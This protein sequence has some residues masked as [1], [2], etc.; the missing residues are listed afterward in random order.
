MAHASNNNNK[1]RFRLLACIS[2]LPASLPPQLA[3]RRRLRMPGNAL[4]SCCVAVRCVCG[5]VW[6]TGARPLPEGAGHTL[7]RASDREWAVSQSPRR[8]ECRRDSVLPLH[9][10]EHRTWR[11]HGPRGSRSVHTAPGC[12]T[13]ALD[14]DFS[15]RTFSFSTYTP[16]GVCEKTSPLCIF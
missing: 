6:L 12:A 16:T 4:G 15:W 14:V 1:P 9:A 11:S 5:C 10:R 7:P 3:A 8:P 2:S 13:K